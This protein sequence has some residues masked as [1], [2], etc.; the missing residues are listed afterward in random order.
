MDRGIDMSSL[1]A[2][3][4]KGSWVV[5]GGMS[6]S[7][8]DND[9]A[10]FWI[11]DDV[12]SNG[13]SLSLSPALCYMT[14]DNMGVGLRAGYRRNMF[15]LDSAKFSLSDAELEFSDYYRIGH[16][17]EIQGFVRYYIPVGPS[18]R[19][20]LFSELQ[21]GCSYGQSKVMDGRENTLNGS[22]ETSR[23]VALAFCPGITAFVSD[24][25]SLDVSV[26][27]FGLGLKKTDQ[28]HNQIEYGSWRS[29]IVSF[30]ADLLSVGFSLYYHI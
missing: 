16:N 23:S 21:L 29:A 27:M 19:L 6:Y 17:F 9:R 26:S 4:P 30:R 20:A 12:S 18:G 8:H 25:I 14:R 2:F 15:Q 13:Y 10:N 22:Y 24:R 3:I 28:T 1:P 11:V 5:G 7:L